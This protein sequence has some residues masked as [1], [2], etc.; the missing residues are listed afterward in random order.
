MTGPPHLD[1][2][3]ESWCS[4]SHLKYSLPF[5]IRQRGRR[6]GRKDGEL[7]REGGSTRPRPAGVRGR[8][9]RWWCAAS[10]WMWH[11]NRVFRIGGIDQSGWMQR[12]WPPGCAEAS[13]RHSARDDRRRAVVPTPLHCIVVHTTVPLPFTRPVW[14]R[15]S[16]MPRSH[17]RGAPPPLDVLARCRI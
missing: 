14:L 2:L 17:R 8:A 13:G 9:A 6:R 1:F 5:S 10:S 11:L 15:E 12:E 7:L 4:F 16:Q 3:S